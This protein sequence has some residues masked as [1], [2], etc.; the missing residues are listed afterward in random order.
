MHRPNG[1][2]R[3]G[4]MLGCR[5]KSVAVCA[6]VQV[7]SQVALDMIQTSETLF[8]GSCAL[9]VVTAFASGWRPML[10]ALAL[11]AASAAHVVDL[12]AGLALLETAP[13]LWVLAALAL[14]ERL[15]DQRALHGHEEDL[16]LSSLRVP[17][18][19]LL[20]AAWAVDLMGAWGWLGLPLG[21]A[22][23]LSGQALKATLRAMGGLLGWDRTVSI[24][25]VLIDL[26][27]PLALWMAWRFPLAALA[28][29]ALILL[30]A[31]PAAV[32]WVRELRSR[33]RRW[34]ALN[35]GG[36]I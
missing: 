9:A 5:A 23:A 6:P 31:L 21:A 17:M 3:A 29:L 35:T 11:A 2:M 34:A 30:V 20:F 25:A 15:A 8:L 12:P 7:V 26:S 16:L 27:V 10:V 19:A 33:W 32:W 14:V 18:G 24:V 4:P 36:V 13:A 22:L 28:F 1:L